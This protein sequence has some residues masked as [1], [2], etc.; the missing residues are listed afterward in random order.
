MLVVDSKVDLTLAEWSLFYLFM[1]A[2]F[3]FHTY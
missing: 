3:D 2:V 1:L